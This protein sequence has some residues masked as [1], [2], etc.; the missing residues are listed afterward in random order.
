MS[1]DESESAGVADTPIDAFE[2]SLVLVSNRQPYSH[3]HEDGEIVV[4]RPVGGLTAGLDPVMQ[5]IDGTWIAWG[6]GDADAE[7]TDENDCVRVPPD[8]PSY[9]L[10]R[11]WLS[12]DAVDEYYYGYSNQVLW[13][14]CHDLVG[15][16][17]FE[18]RFWSRYQEVNEQFAEAVVEQADEESVVWFQDYHLALAPSH[19]RKALPE[20]TLFQFWHIPWPTWDTFRVCPNRRELLDGLLANDLIGF[21]TERYVENFLAC[22]DACFDDAR[23][24]T[25]SGEVEYDGETTLVRAFP[26]GVDAERIGRLAGERDE[27]FWSEFKTEYGIP[28][29]SRVA[30]GVDRLDYTKG[31]PERLDALYHLF[32]TRPEWRERLTY[33]QKAT[34]SRSDIPEYQRLQSE[35]D[36]RIDRLNERFATDSWRPVVRIDEHLTNPELYGLYAHSDL[37]LVTPVRDG[38]NLVAKEYVAAQADGDTDDGVLVLSRM[39]GAHG[40]LGDTAVTIEPYDEAMLADRIEEALTMPDHERERRMDALRESVFENDLDTW[41]ASLL[42]TVQGLRRMNTEQTDDRNRQETKS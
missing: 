32:E 41:L 20:T 13:P 31:I 7:V 19:A 24:D 15:K 5:Q 26:L 9:T 39:T 22:V 37:A 1:P 8:D 18:D 11:V 10:R 30:V 28:D 12:D 6:D 3:R 27:S 35:V 40:E 23:V 29:D 16:T 14:L 21:H 38:M 34:E 4:D 2:S 17:N 33:V 42:G 36:E 25:D